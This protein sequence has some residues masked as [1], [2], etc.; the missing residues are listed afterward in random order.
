MLGQGDSET[1][2]VLMKTMLSAAPF[3]HPVELSPLVAFFLKK[4]K[5]GGTWE[6]Q[7][8]TRCL[9]RVHLAFHIGS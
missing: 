9:A 1:R 2:C 5:N 3:W 7:S 8:V 4:K 6:M